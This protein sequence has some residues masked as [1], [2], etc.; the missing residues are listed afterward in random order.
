MSTLLGCGSREFTDYTLLLEHTRALVV[1]HKIT[2][3]IHGGARGADTLFTRAA[4]EL[5][6]QLRI[7]PADWERYGRKGPDNAGNTRNQEMLDVG[8]PV[9]GLAFPIDRSSG[10]RDMIRRLRL[11]GLPTAIVETKS[12]FPSMKPR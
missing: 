11:A 8:L 1:E 9:A 2:R 6:L 7:F 3:I 5:N 4:I 10:T 12:W